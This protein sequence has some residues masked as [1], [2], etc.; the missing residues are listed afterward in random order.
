MRRGR[1]SRRARPRE[2]GLGYGNRSE[3]PLEDLV[4]LHLLGERLVREDESVPEC[5]EGERLVAAADEREGTRRLDETD[6]AARAGSERDVGGE[7]RE[8]VRRRLTRR[9]GD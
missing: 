5:V 6:R 8:T 3:H 7:F 9:N 4:R 2:I 1:V